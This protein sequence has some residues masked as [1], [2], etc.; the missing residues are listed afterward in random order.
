MLPFENLASL[1]MNNALYLLQVR[2]C[3]TDMGTIDLHEKKVE[4]H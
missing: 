1:F 3:K 4:K 2:T